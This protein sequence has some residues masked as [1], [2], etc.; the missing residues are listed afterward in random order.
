[1]ISV[2]GRAPTDKEV[3][4]YQKDKSHDHSRTGD[5]RVSALVEKD[6]VRLIEE[7]DKFWLFGFTPVEDQD[8]MKSVDAT[9]RVNK[10]TQQ[11]EY[12]DMRNVETIKPGHSVKISKLVTRLTFGPA[13]EGG[14]VV[15]LSTQVEVKGR[16]F[17]VM[18]FD[19]EEFTRN[20][21]FEFVGK[22]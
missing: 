12:I 2:D 16:A 9:I 10:S 5:Q 17:L 4:A 20:S 6:S 21:D 22:P 7:G 11:L 1:M 19:E 3:K 14:P 8:V 18:S 15:P 13:V